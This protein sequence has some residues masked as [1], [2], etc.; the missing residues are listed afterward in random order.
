MQARLIYNRSLIKSPPSRYEEFSC[1][2]TIRRARHSKLFDYQLLSKLS[3]D[4]YA[5]IAFYFIIFAARLEK[6]EL[7]PSR[8]PTNI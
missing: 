6:G 5:F 7:N 4:F 8:P 1:E 2:G 3:M